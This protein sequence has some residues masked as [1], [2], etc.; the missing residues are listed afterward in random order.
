MAEIK[1]IK[2]IENLDL[3]R[4]EEFRDIKLESIREDNS[5]F[6]TQLDFYKNY[7]QDH[8]QKELFNHKLVFA[9]NEGK[10]IGISGITF[11]KNEKIKHNALLDTL[12]INKNFRGIGVG[13]KLTEERINICLKKEDIIN[14]FCEIF[15]SQKESIELHK[16]LGFEVVGKMPNF[17]K[18]EGEFLDN[19]NLQKKIR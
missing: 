2:I 4:W 9:E 10:L 13:K 8:W 11:Y 18:H 1:N 16:K 14:V 7:T 6:Y 15:S 17:L 19:Y 5:A 12:F 3:E